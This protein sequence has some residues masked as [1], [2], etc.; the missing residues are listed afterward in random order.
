MAA[1]I[2]ITIKT[3]HFDFDGP[4]PIARIYCNLCQQIICSL[5]LWSITRGQAHNALPYL[6]KDAHIHLTFKHTNDP[7][8]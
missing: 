8:R 7:T 5:H 6:I 2:T 1:P 4:R 3:Q